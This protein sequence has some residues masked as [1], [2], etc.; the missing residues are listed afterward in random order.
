MNYRMIAKLLGLVLRFVA[1][2]MLPALA[3]SLFRKEYAAAMGFGI[4]I[5][6]M[7]ILSF[8]PKLFKLKRQTMY[9]RDGYVLVSLTWFLISALGAL[10]FWISRAIPNYVDCFFEVV[11]GFTTTG[12]SILTDVEALPVGL[13]YWR[14]FTHWLGGMGVLVFLL[15]IARFTEGAGDSMH[16]M[17]A[18]SPGP[19]VSKLVPHTFR[20]AQILYLIYIVLTVLQAVLLLLGDMP[21]F[22]AVTTAFGTAGTG[23]F[24]IK[25]DS[26]AGYSPYIQWVV[27]IFMA[28]FGVNFG[29]YYLLLL[30]SFGKVWRNEELRFY[31]GIMLSFGLIIFFNILPSM[32]GHPGDALRHSF[33]QVSSI[34]T[35]TGFATAD[36]NQ[37]P[38]LSRTLLVVLMIVGASA[39]STGGG[40]KC[41]R[42]LILFKCL[43]REVYRML[44]PNTVRQIHMDGEPVSREAIRNAY[45]FMC[46]YCLVA[47][48]STVLISLDG[49][50]LETNFTAMLATLNNI[51]PGLDMVGPTGNFSMFSN[52]SKIVLS[53]NMLLGRLEIFPIIIMCMPTVWKRSRV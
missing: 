26:I 6:I 46:A 12:A 49:F 43:H 28:L 11:S 44:H 30:R 3:I 45:A 42:L 7:V 21:L 14:S 2:F 4:T 35:T 16:I 33:F 22:D 18:E 15:A 34:M 8:L 39:G 52:F 13:L 51:G 25:A 5:L 50:S 24:G 27:T 23:G 40:F 17:R 53:V 37:W 31:L 38:Q 1:V 29:V 48:V 20:S 9:A 36:F 19:Q 10:P 32:P 47:I 41:S